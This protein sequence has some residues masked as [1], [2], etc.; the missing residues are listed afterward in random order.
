MLSNNNSDHGQR[1]FRLSP[2][3]RVIIMHV[4]A[5]MSGHALM[6]NDR[7]WISRT[8]IPFGDYFLH[9]GAI[10]IVRFGPL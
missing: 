8:L 4:A 5:P 10:S 3:K 1:V 6:P 9:P 7:T 2:V